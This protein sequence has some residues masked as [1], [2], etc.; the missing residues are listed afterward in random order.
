MITDTDIKKLEK[1]FVTK[2]ELAQLRDSFDL[3]RSSVL[4]SN[5]EKFSLKTEMEAM[6]AESI[7]NG[8]KLD[9]LL[10]SKDAY[11]GRISDLD[12][13]NKMGAVTTA[14]HTRQIA[15]LAKKTKVAL[16]E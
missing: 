10:T 2:K 1:T 4:Q 13:E 16:S 9:Q 7:R 5:F 14:R 12:Q 6:R 11:A 8:D 15:E 3:L